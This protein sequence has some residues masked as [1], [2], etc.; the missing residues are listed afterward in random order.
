MANRDRVPKYRCHSSG[1][2]LEFQGKCHYFGPH[3]SAESREQYKGFVDAFKQSRS[4][5]LDTR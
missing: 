3:G 1:Q 5:L 2:A 4:P